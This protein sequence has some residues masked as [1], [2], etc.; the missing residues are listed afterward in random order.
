[1]IYDTS[2]LKSFINKAG[3][4]VVDAAKTVTDAA[5]TTVDA[6]P[7]ALKIREKESYLEKQYFE[8]GVLYFQKHCKDE[9]FEFE[10]MQRICEVQEELV[11]LREELAE[12][13]GKDVCPNCGEYVEKNVSYC[14]HCGSKLDHVV[15]EQSAEEIFEEETEK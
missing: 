12:K 2:Q 3:D 14:S 4:A 5:K 13:K 11:I 9:N 15:Y 8:L 10:Q 1:M 7:I 6:A